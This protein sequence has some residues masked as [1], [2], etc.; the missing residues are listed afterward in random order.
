M[1]S[2]INI[3]NVFIKADFRECIKHQS[4]D[5]YELNEPSFVK[6]FITSFVPGP[7]SFIKKKKTNNC[8]VDKHCTCEVKHFC[9][10]LTFRKVQR[11]QSNLYVRPP[12]ISDGQSKTPKLSQSKCLTIEISSKRPPPDSDRNHFLGLKV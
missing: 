1:T 8:S 7:S 3:R 5:L 2:F 10:N 6:H 4:T 12:P 9:I 11:I